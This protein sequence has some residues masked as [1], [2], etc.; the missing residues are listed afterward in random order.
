MRKCEPVMQ[1]MEEPGTRNDPEL[2]RGVEVEQLQRHQRSQVRVLIVAP[3]TMTAEF[4]TTTLT[5]RTA[6]FKVTV[7]IGNADSAIRKLRTRSPHVALISEDLQEGPQDGFKV[8]QE[9]R[10]SRANTAGVMLLKRSNPS[11]VLAAFR[12]GARGIFYRT[13]S[14]KALPKCIQTVHDGQIWIGNEDLEAIMDSLG[15]VN[16]VLITGA[17]GSSLLTNREQDVVRLV[18][19]GMKN[20]EVAQTLQLTEHSVRN[21]LY[22]IFDKLGVSS[23]AELILYALSQ[24]GVELRAKVSGRGPKALYP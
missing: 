15:R 22:R 23:R 6:H 9:M 5:T 19:D 13:H 7:S 14:L 24:L 16:A 20:R 12:S 2:V 11:L 18:V 17:N 21:Y 3:D 1:P 10:H 8:L 4:L